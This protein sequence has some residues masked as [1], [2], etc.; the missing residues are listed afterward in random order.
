M[1][2][3]LGDIAEVRV[4]YFFRSRL[5]HDP[6]GDVLVVQMK[7]LDDKSDLQLDGAAR[8]ALPTGKSRHLLKEGD[9]LFRSR[10]RSTTAALVPSDL[11]PAVL[12]A[13]MLLIRPTRVL[14][15]YLQWFINSGNTQRVL[16]GMAKGTLVTMIGATELR[17]LEV[18]IPPPDQQRKIAEISKL[19]KTEQR[20]MADIAERSEKWVEAV[21]TRRAR[22]TR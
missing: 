19:A 11:G 1:I 7:D 16:A 12:S 8:V 13:P 2:R 5:E 4:G 9:L 14:P 21:L 22:N 15:A 3:A 18:P 20:L 17:S 10:G 6:K